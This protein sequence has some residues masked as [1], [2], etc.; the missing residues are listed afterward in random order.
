A[1]GRRRCEGSVAHVADDADDRV[2]ILTVGK[3]D[4]PFADRAAAGGIVPEIRGRRLADDRF[5]RPLL[6]HSVERPASDQRNAARAKIPAVGRRAE[7][8]R[9]EYYRR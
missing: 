1:R 3:L 2:P 4:E 6:Q 7:L 5:V 8:M 9:R